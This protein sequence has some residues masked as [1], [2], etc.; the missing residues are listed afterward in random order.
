MSHDECTPS[1]RPMPTPATGD[2]PGYE[3]RDAS[4]SGLLSSGSA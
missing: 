1:T 2:G 3:T 4:V